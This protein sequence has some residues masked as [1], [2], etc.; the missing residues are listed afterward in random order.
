MNEIV[1]IDIETT[2]LSPKTE[3]IIEIGA[4]IVNLDTYEE[5]ALYETL[6]KP[7]KR[8]SPFITRLTGITNKDVENGISIE[9]ALSELAEFCGNRNM[10]AHN[11]RFDKGFIRH[12]LTETET[13]YTETEWVDTIKIFRQSFPGRKSYKLEGLIKDFALAAKEDHRAVSDARHTFSLMKIAE[14]K[15]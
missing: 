14:Y 7:T 8:I 3:Q 15:G 1:L 10:Y 4:I 12:F 6:V 2:G 9:R 13:N 11:A 5:V